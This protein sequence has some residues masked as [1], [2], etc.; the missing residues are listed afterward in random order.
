MVINLPLAEEILLRFRYLLTLFCILGLTPLPKTT[1]IGLKK[2]KQPRVFFFISP[3][4][5][6]V[7]P[8]PYSAQDL[9]Q[10]R[11]T[12]YDQINFNKM[13][14]IIFKLSVVSFKKNS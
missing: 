3:E 12:V 1:V 2:Y 10:G 5:L 8:D 14:L 11:H 6:W 9:L 13:D 4:L 7:P